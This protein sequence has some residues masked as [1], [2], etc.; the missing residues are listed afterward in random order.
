MAIE[1]LGAAIGGDDGTVRARQTAS[2]VGG[3]DQ[4]EIVDDHRPKRVE[5]VCGMTLERSCAQGW[6]SM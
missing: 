6:V 1:V 3:G 5:A 2:G 4:H